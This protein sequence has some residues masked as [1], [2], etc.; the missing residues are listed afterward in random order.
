MLTPTDLIVLQEIV[1][2]DGKCL[3]SFRCSIC[4]FRA[5]CLPEF[6]DPSPPTQ[7][8]RYRLALDV[9]SLD[10]IMGDHEVERD[11]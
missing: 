11:A 4:P 3:D 9:L 10:S 7:N 1:D 8:Q 6:L 5:K 2:L